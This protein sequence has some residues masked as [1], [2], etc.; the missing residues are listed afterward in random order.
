MIDIE[1][2]AVL[3]EQYGEACSLGEH[4]A[5][6]R[7]LRGSAARRE[8]HAID[9]LCRSMLADAFAMRMMGDAEEAVLRALIAHV[10]GPRCESRKAPHG[11]WVYGRCGVTPPSLRRECR[12]RL[13][14]RGDRQWI[15]GTTYCAWTDP[16]Q[17]HVRGRMCRRVDAT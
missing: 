13:T 10:E 8:Y 3:I 16:R 7:V 12:E 5:V 14:W 15:P 17:S 6:Y 4:S 11:S 9:A 2:L 1:G